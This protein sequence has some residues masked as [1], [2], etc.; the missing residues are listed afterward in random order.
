VRLPFPERI[1]LDYTFYFAGILCVIQLLQGTNG[2]FALGCSFFILIAVL[3]FNHAGGFTRPTGSY[4]F[5]FSTLTLIVGICW[6]AILGEPADSNLEDPLL[7]IGVY[8]GCIFSMYVSVVISRR[9][10]AKRAFLRNTVTDA[11]MQTATVGCM[12]TG[13]LLFS[14]SILFPNSGGN[15]TVF[16][17]L[18]QINQ[19]FPLAIILGTIHT[20]RRSGGTRSVNLPVLICILFSSGVGI[21]GFSKQ[22]IIAPLIC[23]ILAAASQRYRVSKTQVIVGVLTTFFIFHYM[24]PYA[25]YGRNYRVETISGNF[26]VVVSMLSDLGHVREQYLISSDEA[27]QASAHG[28]YNTPQGFFDRLE[29]IALDDSLMAFKRRNGFDGLYPVVFAFQN[30]VPHFIW[31]D[32][33]QFHGGNGFAHEVGALADEDVT[34]GVSFSAAADAYAFLGWTGVFLLA[35]VLWIILFTLFDSLCGD[36]RQAPWGILVALVYSHLGPEGGLGGIIYTYGYTCFGIVFSA[37]VGAYVMPVMGTLFIGPEGIIVRRGAKIESIPNRLRPA[38]SKTDALK[39]R[40][41]SPSE[42]TSQLPSESP[43]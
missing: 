41:E 27:Q 40:G 13:F 12:V 34:T 4:V 3:A 28:Y 23:W 10:T 24:V 15:G 35:P 42:S 43:G 14:I 38:S 9:L 33:P 8:L 17:A 7:G 22:G 20:I 19:F 36:L 11:N 37:I 6:K 31:K 32:K 30:L 39:L 5:F 25:Q 21:F 1:P 16:S 18:A 2:L 26:A 29:A